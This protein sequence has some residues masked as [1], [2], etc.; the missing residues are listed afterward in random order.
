M[1]GQVAGAKDMDRISVSPAGF[2]FK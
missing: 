1:V 2:G